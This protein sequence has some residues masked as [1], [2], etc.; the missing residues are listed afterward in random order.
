MRADPA[1]IDPA[2]IEAADRHGA[3]RL[4]AELRDAARRAGL[5]TVDIT[6]ADAFEE[7]RRVLRCRKE[8]GLHGGMHFTYGNPERSTDPG[9]LLPG[10]RAV[11]VATCSYRAVCSESTSAPNV[12]VVARYSRHDAYAPLRQG[13]GAISRAVTDHGWRAA[14]SCDDNSLVDRAAA[15]RAGVG[16]YGRNT[17]LLRPGVGSWFLIGSV[18][19]D[20]PLTPTGE[21]L[22]PA[23]GCGPCRR[24]LQA[25][26]TGALDDGVLDARRCLAWLL[27]A[28]GP[29]PR[30][31]RA[32]LGGRIYGCDDCQTACPINRRAERN[33]QPNAAPV[34]DEAVVDLLDV[35]A[36]DDQQLTD[37]FRRWYIPRRQGRYIRRNALVALGNVGDGSDPMVVTALER[38]LRDPDPLVRGHAVWA[39]ARLGRHDLLSSMAGHESDPDVTDELRWAAGAETPPQ[40]P[41]TFGVLT[42]GATRR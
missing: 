40:G 24:C 8:A 27:E 26:P 41:P 36:T 19:T 4:T 34:D 13:L 10:A 39:S 1:D 11:V 28:P 21:P 22:E 38:A 37:R 25:C 35:L 31:Y 30:R 2:D 12:G 33:R 9:R 23:A 16:F 18:V 6:T 14:T 32:A 3:E 17:M 15:A 5:D 7:T 29:F 42:P 20:A